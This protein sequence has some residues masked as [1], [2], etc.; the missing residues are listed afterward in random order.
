[1]EEPDRQTRKKAW[2]ATANRRLLDREAIDGIYDR[3]LPLR[4]TIAAN[5]GLSDFRAYAWKS[6]KRFDYLPEDCLRFA[7]AIVESCVPVVKDLDRQRRAQMGLSALRPWDFQ[8]DPKGR[9]AL[10]PFDEND[11]DGFVDRVKA[12][13][14][15]MSPGLAVEFESLRARKNLDLQSRKSKQPGG[16]QCSLEEAREP[17]HFHERGGSAAGCRDAVA[18]GR[19]CVSLLGGAE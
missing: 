16:Y 8:V 14:G 12:I 6:Y 19:A 10:R 11:V 5:A 15:R 18:R 1:M 4:Q 7:D 13:F 17:S 3:L 2:E 9:A